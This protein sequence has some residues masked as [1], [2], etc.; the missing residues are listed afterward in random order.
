MKQVDYRG[1]SNPPILHRKEL[2]LAPTDPRRNGFAALTRDAEELGLFQEAHKA[3]T[4][5]RWEARLRGARVGV[6]DHRLVPLR[7]VG[8]REH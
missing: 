7:Q 4:R 8:R 2:L 6:Q 5:E 1:R 3:G